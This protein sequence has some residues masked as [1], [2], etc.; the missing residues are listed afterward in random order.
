MPDP[1]LDRDQLDA[2][3]Q[4]A[5]GEARGYLEGLCRDPVV[6][7]DAEAAIERWR[8]P[9]P[10]DGDGALEALAELASRG[11]DAAMRSSGPRFFHFVM[12]GGTPAAR[13]IVRAAHCRDG[14]F[15]SS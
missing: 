13:S 8:D 12:G 10:E 14:R 6:P 2:A 5:A 7:R 9:M 3:L 15:N 1:L 4:F 11:R